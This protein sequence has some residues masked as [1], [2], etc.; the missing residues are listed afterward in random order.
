MTF[1][2]IKIYA[3]IFPM[4]GLERFVD[5]LNMRDPRTPPLQ[6]DLRTAIAFQNPVYVEAE[7]PEDAIEIAVDL[8]EAAFGEIFYN[9]TGVIEMDA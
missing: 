8:Y 9:L 1:Y 6:S 4:C 7:T 5:A 3:H 2:R